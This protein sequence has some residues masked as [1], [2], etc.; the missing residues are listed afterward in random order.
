VFPPHPVVRFPPAFNFLVLYGLSNFYP[1]PEIINAVSLIHKMKML[2]YRQ[3]TLGYRTRCSEC[4]MVQ[5]QFCGDCLYMR[6]TLFNCY[7]SEM[8]HR[9]DVMIFFFGEYVMIFIR[10]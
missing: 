1:W 10:A 4:N 2:F 6:Y 8:Y 3:K 7:M 5:G 9:V